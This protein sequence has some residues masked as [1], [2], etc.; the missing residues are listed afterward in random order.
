MPPLDNDVA[1]PTPS[2]SLNE[3]AQPTRRLLDRVAG[4]SVMENLA[5]LQSSIPARSAWARFWGYS[6]LIA[7]AASWYSG[8]LGE[9]AVG[10]LLTNLEGSWTVL[11]A[12][13]V[14]KADSD[15]DHIVIG[16]GGVFTINTKH[17]P[18]KNVWV[19]SR[20]FMVSGQKVPYLRNARHEAARATKL[21]AAVLP[22]GIE[23]VPIIAVVNPRK[24][25]I[26]EA[27]ADVVVRDAS[28]L[29]R[30]L[31]KR[32]HVLDAAQATII[33]SAATRAN[34]WHTNSTTPDADVRTTLAGFDRL[35]REVRS[36]GLRRGLW[37]AAGVLALVSAALLLMP[38]LIHLLT[39]TIISSF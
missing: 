1:V 33:V 15:I 11:H 9:R 14:G 7:D 3:N 16:P 39:T 10:R 20:A 30:W 19:G 12:V 32:P 22:T 34:T 37:A 18:D 17:H 29:V 8:A 5:R 26:R 36:A 28:G 2:A 13:P 38:T 25:T 24:L 35:D 23:V 4:Q 6:P 21:L 31:R 27:P